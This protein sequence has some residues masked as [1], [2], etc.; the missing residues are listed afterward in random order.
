[1][2]FESVSIVMARLADLHGVGNE[3]AG[4]LCALFKSTFTPSSGM[5]YAD[6]AAAEADFAGYARSAALVFGTPYADSANR[7]VLAAASVQFTSTGAT[8]NNTIGGYA[9]LDSAGTGLLWAE[10]FS[11]NGA[12]TPILIDA[13][14]KAITVVPIYRQGRLAA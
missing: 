7:A 13:A 12:P 8:P 4:A 3:W 9:V 1:M 2:I 14:S 5:T 10:M 6:F 11:L